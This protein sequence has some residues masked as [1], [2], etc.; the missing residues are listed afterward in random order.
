M[1]YMLIGFR[2]FLMTI[3]LLI[4]VRTMEE[5]Y[6]YNIIVVVIC[7]IFISIDLISLLLGINFLG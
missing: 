4:Y 5:I 2:I 1:N 6:F 3:L 7:I